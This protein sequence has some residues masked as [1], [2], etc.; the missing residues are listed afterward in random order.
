MLKCRM[1]TCIHATSFVFIPLVLL[2]NCIFNTIQHI[3]KERFKQ[4]TVGTILFGTIIQQWKIRFRIGCIRT[5]VN[6]SFRRPWYLQFELSIKNILYGV[7]FKSTS[8]KF[9]SHSI[10]TF[11]WTKLPLFIVGETT[12]DGEGK[13]FK[14]T[15]VY[16]TATIKYR[17]ISTRANTILKMVESISVSNN[18]FTFNYFGD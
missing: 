13:Q 5:V 12:M 16:G 1:Q 8:F 15:K 7:S 6:F 4:L 10:W 11:H 14:A 3:F 9:F 2:R 18:N 17:S